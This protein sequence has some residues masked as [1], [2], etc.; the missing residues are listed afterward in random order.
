MPYAN[1][2]TISSRTRQASVHCTVLSMVSTGDTFGADHLLPNG[3]LCAVPCVLPSERVTC[4]LQALAAAPH[5]HNISHPFL[6]PRSFLSSRIAGVSTACIV[7][8]ACAGAGLPLALSFRMTGGIC[9][10][11][12][13]AHGLREAVRTESE[14]QH[15]DRERRREAWELSNFREGEE[16]EMVELYVSKG[17]LRADAEVAITALA[18]HDAFFVDL[19]MSQELGLQ[20]PDSSPW[21]AAA[22]SA[23]GF[24]VS[25]LLPLAIIR[26]S[27]LWTGG[28]AVAAVSSGHVGA[29]RPSSTLPAWALLQWPHLPPYPPSSPSSSSSSWMLAAQWVGQCAGVFL[30]QQGPGLG[31]LAFSLTLALLWA[32]ATGR[33]VQWLSKAGFVS[34]VTARR[35]MGWPLVFNP[36]PWVGPALAA[37]TL[38][39]STVAFYSVL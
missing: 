3:V 18:R 15:Y 12:G 17:V 11:L 24:L 4:P 34:P 37:V 35:W 2:D 22:C 5:G 36:R 1:R 29:L 25:S 31:L 14:R 26:W 8:A 38:L 33:P 32:L 6:P 19:M 21:A 7:F 9:S 13:V 16:A 30:T 28:D 20:R 39:T 10:A 27:L 23:A